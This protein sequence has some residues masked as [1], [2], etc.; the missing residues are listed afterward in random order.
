MYHFDFAVIQ[1]YLVK[2]MITGGGRLLT[3]IFREFDMKKILVGLGCLAVAFSA[4]AADWYYYGAV[5]DSKSIAVYD[6]ESVHE[7]EV[8][9]TEAWLGW[10]NS[11]KT[12]SYDTH[13]TLA[14][15]DCRGRRFRTLMDAWYVRG[16]YLGADART[17]RWEYC[18][19]GS[20]A[21]SAL[22]AA[23]ELRWFP[24]HIKKPSYAELAKW[25]KEIIKKDIKP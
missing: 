13:L 15:F 1:N 14:E 10:I 3:S 12:V 9:N 21:N 24:K 5:P 25:G 11:D 4:Q 16:R 19:P 23:C 20:V 2:S 17:T 8:G 22:N 6:A 18:V 7:N